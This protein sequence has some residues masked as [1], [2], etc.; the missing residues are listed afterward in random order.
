M[1]EKWA[2]GELKATALG[3]EYQNMYHLTIEHTPPPWPKGMG[4]KYYAAGN[5]YFSNF[6]GFGE[7]W[8]VLA[9]EERFCIPMAGHNVVGIADLV[10]RHRET[11]ELV[12]IDHKSK[13]KKSMEKEMDHYRRQLYIYA[14]FVHHKWGQY[15]SKI[16]F[17]MFREGYTIVEVFE[18]AMLE[19]TERWIDETI[20]QIHDE[21]LFLPMPNQFFCQ[22]LCDVSKFCPVMGGEPFLKEEKSQ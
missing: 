21:E 15:P 3:E 8:E 10:L 11:G 4:E 14:A 16:M 9:V 13:S 17:N 19:E 7:E 1:L 22:F 12:V 6:S 2:K 5:D 20:A 18:I